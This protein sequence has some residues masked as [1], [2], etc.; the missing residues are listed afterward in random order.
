MGGAGWK[1]AVCPYDIRVF[2]SVRWL[3]VGLETMSDER[4]GY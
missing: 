1:E 4:A 2:V 3:G